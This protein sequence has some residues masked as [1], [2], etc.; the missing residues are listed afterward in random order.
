MSIKIIYS[1]KTAK[2]LQSNTVIFVDEKFNLNNVKK[3]ISN[4]EFNYIKDLLKISDLKKNIFVF[5]VNSKKKIILISIKKHSKSYDME[6]L[7]A[8][9]Y[10]KIN[11]GKKK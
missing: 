5:E 4:T 1:N 2:P 3:F 9:L 8:E 10:N 6:N 7:G 11:H